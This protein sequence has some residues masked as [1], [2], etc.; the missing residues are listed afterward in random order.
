M[1]ALSLLT[2][3]ALAGPLVS[4]EAEPVRTLITNV[5]VLG[6]D[7]ALAGIHDVVLAEGKIDAVLPVG[8]GWGVP[9]ERT[10][11]GSGATLL[12]GLID[13]HVHLSS[14]YAMPD[15][16]R[17]PR[18]QVNLEQ[19]LYWGVTTVLD[20]SE[21]RK[22]IESHRKN[23]ASGRWSGPNIYASGMP[24]APPSGHPI[25]TVRAMFPGLL[26]RLATRG[27]THAVA[28]SDQV[29]RG[30]A[31]EGAS[32]FTKV[33]ID[34]LPGDAPVIADEPLQ[35]LRV[36][37]TALDDTLI[38]HVGQPQDVVRAVALPVDAFAHLPWGGV[39]ED[40]HLQDI[41]DA[42]IE[43]VATLSVWEAVARVREGQP[44]DTPLERES[45]TSAQCADLDRALRGPLKTSGRLDAWADT[46][47]AERETRNE[48]VRRLY[49]AGGDILVG[50]DSPMIGLAAGA[51]THH[52]LALLHAAGLPR[53]AVLS[54]VTWE[55]SRFLQDDARFG[56]VR[57]GWEADLLLV[58]GDP[59]QDLGALQAIR[60]LWVDG[61]RVDRATAE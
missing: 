37:A 35:R 38:A 22:T 41:V 31:Q 29:D 60:E 36:G 57:T 15:R 30:L 17:I 49:D 56:A 23:L 48:N 25:S 40:S 4:V 39:L 11:D 26:T 9:V 54:A 33:M 6:T 2:S 47:V 45:L 18:A 10:I 43:A 55:N 28:T 1:A 51:G 46:L 24:F 5:G 7:G 19:F 53:E 58:E 27:T 13:A 3:L 16:V 21:D 8:E 12:P 52:E 34:S 14:T 59:T 20:L 61:R 32:G 42:D 44:W 50:S